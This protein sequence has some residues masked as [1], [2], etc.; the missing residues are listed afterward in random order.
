MISNLFKGE[1]KKVNFK[2]KNQAGVVLTNADL[3][4]VNV[5]VTVSGKKYATYKFTSPEESFEIT[6]N[7]D[8]NAFEF[9]LNRK[10]T[11]EFPEGILTIEILT[12]MTNTDF[13]DNFNSVA[14]VAVFNVIKS[15]STGL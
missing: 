4:D 8:L 10:D 3:I 12:K 9:E 14:Q 13:V 2:I 5:V 15:F 7:N 1:S 6:F 11:K